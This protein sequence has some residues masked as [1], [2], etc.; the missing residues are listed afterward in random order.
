MGAKV[1]AV[2]FSTAMVELLSQKTQRLGLT[3]LQSRV[4]DGTALDLEDA[5]FDVVGSQFGVMLFPDRAAGLSEM[6][7][8]TRPGGPDL[9]ECAFPRD[10]HGG[11]VDGH[12]QRWARIPAL[13]GAQLHPRE[14]RLR[15][16][17]RHSRGIWN[18]GILPTTERP[19]WKSN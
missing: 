9:F 8:A 7:R 6:A 4:M 2:D 11:V 16:M 19:E 3:N 12:S 15:T 17:A 18:R 13:R 5:S 14:P 1:L 10:C